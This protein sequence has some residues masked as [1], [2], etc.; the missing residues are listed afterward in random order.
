MAR[1]VW[2]GVARN[3][4]REI[5]SFI[6][7]DSP[8]YARSFG[9]RIQRRVQQLEAFP[10]SGRPVPEDPTG[11]YRELIIGNYRLI[12]LRDEEVVTIVVVIHGARALRL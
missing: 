10:D 8:A 2:S 7:T 11:V 5:I 9:V 4:F 1:V 12:Y 3:N 6:G